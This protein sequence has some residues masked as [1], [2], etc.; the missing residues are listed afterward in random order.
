MKQPNVNKSTKGALAAAVAGV[1]LLGGAGSLAYW[2]DS[3]TVSGGSIAS[4]SLSLTQEAGQVC[5]DW[6]L[7]AAGGATT[8]TPGVTLVVPGDVITKVCDYTVNASGAHLAADLTMD[9]TSIT[10]S[11]AL[12]AALTPSATYVLGGSVVATG[13]DITSAN[14]GDVL[15]AQISV[16]FASATS[17]LTAQGMTAGLDN[18]V[19]SLVQTH[20]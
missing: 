1:L 14:D 17:G 2:N 10:G 4:G 9:A 15:N 8:Y 6:T 12:S 16:T 19:V 5:S 11:N 7:D 18:I 13:Q 20:P 3:K